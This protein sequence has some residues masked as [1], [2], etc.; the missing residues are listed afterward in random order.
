MEKFL[1]EI[2]FNKMTGTLWTHKKYGIMQF[3]DAEA[4]ESI[5]EKIY[6]RGWNECQAMI[7]GSL[8]IDKV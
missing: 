5:I 2:G 7:R 1:K 8:G 3:D 6:L 4:K